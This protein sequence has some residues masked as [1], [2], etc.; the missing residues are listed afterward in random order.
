[1]TLAQ[2]QLDHR[3]YVSIAES[4]SEGR[5]SG[6]YPPLLSEA[7]ALVTPE[8]CDILA[9]LERADLICNQALANLQERLDSLC[10]RTLITLFQSRLES[11]P[12]LSYDEF[13]QQ[14]QDND[15]RQVITERFPELARLQAVTVNGWRNDLLSVVRCAQD[16]QRQLTQLGVAGVVCGVSLGRGDTHRG[17]RSAAFVHFS[18]ETTLAFKPVASDMASFVQRLLGRIDP[19]HTFFGQ[20]LPQSLEVAGHQWEAIVAQHSVHSPTQEETWMLRAGRLCALAFALGTTDLH[21]ENLVATAAGPVIVD[22]ETLTSLPPLLAEGSA[23]EA[24]SAL[25]AQLEAGPLRTMLLPTR[26]L[27]A[28]LDVENS[29]LGGAWTTDHSS[30][31]MCIRVTGQGTRDIRFGSEPAQLPTAHNLLSRSD[32]TSVDPRAHVDAVKTGYREAMHL[33]RTNRHTLEA[34]TD[35]TEIAQFRQVVRPT[36]IYA[37]YLEASTHPARLDDVQTRRDL[38]QGMK[39]AFPSL[40]PALAS[41]VA[42][43]EVRA[44]L[45]L[46]VPLFGVNADGSLSDADSGGALGSTGIGT[47]ECV[48]WWIRQALDRDDDSDAELIQVALDAACDDAYDAVNAPAIRDSLNLPWLPPRVAWS[49]HREQATW[50]S[51]L[52]F[53]EGLRLGPVPLAFYE[54]G[55]TLLELSQQAQVSDDLQ[56]RQLVRAVTRAAVWHTV[57]PDPEL[58]EAVISP[59][60]G[61]LADAVSIFEL[62]RAGVEV[63]SVLLEHSVESLQMAQKSAGLRL[64][65]WR[66]GDPADYLN[67]LSGCLYAL[68][69][70]REYLPKEGNSDLAQGAA[71]I[72]QHGLAYLAADGT[73]GLAH[74]A[75][76]GLVGL[77]SLWKL[78]GVQPLEQLTKEG[79]EQFCERR[80]SDPALHQHG[81]REAWCRGHAG[82]VLGLLT[83][84]SHLA[85]PRSDVEDSLGWH[86]EV[87]TRT[88]LPANSDLS[89]CHGAA[90]PVTALAMASAA[91]E[92]ADLRDHAHRRVSTFHDHAKKHG[93]RSGLGRAPAAAGFLMGRPGWELAARCV[94]TPDLIPSLVGGHQ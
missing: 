59:F 65:R 33:L 11:D 53:G 63:D 82:I 51:G 86:L 87:L 74:G 27:G 77:S 4:I 38:L 48:R 52:L 6:Y 22:S 5:F 76:G 68:Q 32:G 62:T 21:R 43:A 40:R 31:M 73:S 70:Y 10:I 64:S 78:T 23:D 19:E 89:L 84:Q 75:L 71:D 80:T 29:G 90:G 39:A 45:N 14:L 13:D 47:A 35:S 36:W 85:A 91:L 66:P 79:L 55:G 8:L 24:F 46:D 88:D 81:G 56:L 18:C 3:S 12:R 1:M 54:G 16:D 17:G 69:Q 60:T 7:A 61:A 2:P 41:D 20:V 92:N 49:A 37:R 93:W 30:T 83:V 34:M 26:F 28:K 15:M 44:L 94:N 67:G 57:S 42:D 72:A 25:R 58:P 50:L 9:D